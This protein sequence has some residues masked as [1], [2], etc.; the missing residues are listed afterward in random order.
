[1][2]SQG[3]EPSRDRLK[4]KICLVGDQGVGKTSLIRRLVLDVY[5]DQYITTVGTKVSKKQ[6]WIVFPAT[7]ETIDVDMMIWDIMGEPEYRSVLRE[8][9]FAGAQG[10][11]AVCDLTRRETLEGLFAWIEAADFVAV[12]PSIL[13]V[14]NKADLKDRAQFGEA[15]LARTAHALGCS[16]LTTSAKSGENV[17]FAFQSLTHSIF[18]RLRGQTPATRGL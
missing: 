18:Q 2:A 10:I 1:M 6:M 17:Q 13:V 5:D 4:T 7:G 3:S 12:D 9:Y 8:A 16:F 14:A 15:E 11:L